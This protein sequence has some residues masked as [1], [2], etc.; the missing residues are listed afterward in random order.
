MVAPTLD[1]KARVLLMKLRKGADASVSLPQL[2]RV[3]ELLGGWRV[4]EI[5]G[6]VPL[7][8]EK[9]ESSHGEMKYGL[10]RTD[11]AQARQVYDT[12]RS[13]QVDKLPAHPKLGHFYVKELEPFRHRD[14][15]YR[16]AYGAQYK[17]WAGLPGYRVT[18]PRGHVFELL[19][20]RHDISSGRSLGEQDLGLP[21]IDAKHVKKRLRTYNL[22]PWLKKET[23][24]LDQINELLGT[25]P[26][27]P[28]A[29]RTRENTGSCGA[30]FE[31]IKLEAGKSGGLPVMV[32]H[33]YRRPGIGHVV[34]RCPGEHLPPYEL[35]P[36][37]TKKE[38]DN[39]KRNYQATLEYLNRVKAGAITEF[40]AFFGGPVV[41]KSE[42][43]S[44]V[45]EQELRSHANRLTN[46]LQH[47]EATRKVY[48]WLVTHWE[49]RALPRPNERVF[50]WL[51]HAARQLRK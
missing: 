9:E 1:D 5:V 32:L 50:Q 29:P 37:A 46:E 36:E 44:T 14:E 34:G 2:F 31:N 39:L 17:V 51:E 43:P 12:L 27:M 4:E 22:L 47:L 49:K 42:L 25:E 33:G 40:S 38:L 3:L 16:Q 18:D 21:T 10:W 23:T 7:H 45:W 15:G 28:A 30:C 19:P 48:E 6:L 41:R 24:Y 20:T 11:E 35:S 26:H 8:Y 13:L